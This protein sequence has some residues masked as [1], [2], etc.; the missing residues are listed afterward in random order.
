MDITDEITKIIG[1]P[2]S[3]T[4]EYKAVLP[5]S[6]NIAQ[7]I[8]SFANANGGYIILG[9]S[10]NLEIN[11]LSSDFHANTITHKALDLLSPQPKIYYQY[12]FYNGKRLYVIKIDKSESP[13]FL[14][15]KLYKRIEDKTQL[16]NPTEIIFKPLGY[17]RIQT[18]S[19]QLESYKKDS[20]SSKIKILEHYQSVLK[21]I[22]E[23]GRILYPIDANIPTDNQEGKIL[24]RIL[25]SSCA[26]N[27]ETYLS[28]LLY[29]IFLAEPS[30]LKSKQQVTLEEVLNC[31]DLQE[32]VNYWAYKQIGK[33]QKGSVKGFIKENSQIKDLGVIDEAV[34]NE[35]EKILQIRH[36]Y[37]HRNGIVDEKFLQYFTRQFT[38][39]SEH[40]MSINEICDKLCYLAEIANKIDLAATTKYKLAIAHS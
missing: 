9:A 2:E 17:A 20:T 15:D 5:P 11:G 28:D 32:F 8:S 18:I 31:S 24:S 40:Q 21:I 33:L 13:V 19:S 14:E 37:S 7:L 3:S 35:I 22:D 29:E 30:T 10:D 12:V 16:Q 38:L 34:Q 6:R 25:F 36:L 23:L 26:D 39:T 4:L 27:F 1:Q